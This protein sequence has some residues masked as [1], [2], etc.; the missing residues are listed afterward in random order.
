MSYRVLLLAVLVSAA[1]ACNGAPGRPT[2]DSEVIAPNKVVDFAVL[3]ASNCAG[4]HGA[5]GSGGAAVGLADPVYLAIADDATIR[6][7]TTDGVPGTAMPPFAQ[8]AGGLLTDEQID[9]LVKGIRERWAKPGVLGD[10]DVP[11]YAARAPGNPARGANVYAEYCASCHGD[12][13][14]GGQHASSIVDAAYLALVSDQSL[15]TAVIVGR[16]EM[17]APDWR[18][19]VSGKPMSAEDVTDVVAWMAAQRPRPARA[20]AGNDNTSGSIIAGGLR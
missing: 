1:W 17:G 13:G 6:R 15:R 14:R 18:G 10:R 7:V 3:Y 19:N 12:G 16:P 11:P 9:V 8:S 20:D 2:A 4:C 5:N